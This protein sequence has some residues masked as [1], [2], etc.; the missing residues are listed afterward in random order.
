MRDHIIHAS[1][2][3][4]GRSKRRDRHL[5]WP[6]K[7]SCSV[8]LCVYMYIYVLCLH[9]CISILYYYYC[10]YI[11]I[12]D[13]PSPGPGEAAGPPRV[14]VRTVYARGEGKREGRRL[15]YG[16]NGM[17]KQSPQ[18]SPKTPRPIAYTI[19]NA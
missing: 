3:R 2:R 13:A 11:L 12:N 9:V 4:S 15:L 6:A 18:T 14:A 17:R 19:H 5:F 7:S 8:Y 10:Y 1:R 16:Q